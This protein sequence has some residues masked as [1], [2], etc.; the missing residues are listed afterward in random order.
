MKTDFLCGVSRQGMKLRHLLIPDFLEKENASA[1]TKK[2]MN[3]S[4]YSFAN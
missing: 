1:M 2:W 4:I 3:E